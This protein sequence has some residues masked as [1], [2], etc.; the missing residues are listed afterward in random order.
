MIPE[1]HVDRGYE[2]TNN[3]YFQFYLMISLSISITSY[4]HTICSAVG[5]EVVR[6]AEMANK[7]EQTFALY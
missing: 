3:L 5:P 4:L 6:L 2:M 1:W 7:R